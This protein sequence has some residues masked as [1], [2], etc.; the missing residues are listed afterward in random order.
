MRSALTRSLSSSVLSY[1]KYRPDLA[2]L[3]AKDGFMPGG[4]AI[5]SNDPLTRRDEGLEFPD[6]T[7][8]VAISSGDHGDGDRLSLTNSG[9]S[10][11]D[12][13]LIV[14]VEGLPRGVRLMN[15]SGMTK[16]GAPYLRLF[17]HDGVLN[18]G[19][20]VPVTLRFGGDGERHSEYSLRL[21]SGQGNP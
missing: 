21:L 20:S 10:V 11:I 12:T 7:P 6:V 1:S 2:A 8:Q 18:P 13:H 15:A 9:S 5:D 14:V 16:A 17:L 19:E 3:G 4:L